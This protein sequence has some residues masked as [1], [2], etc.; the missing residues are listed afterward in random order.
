MYRY[1]M[2]MDFEEIS[3]IRE[4]HMNKKIDV[5]NYINK[6]SGFDSLLTMLNCK[7]E[8]KNVNPECRDINSRE[9]QSVANYELSGFIKQMFEFVEPDIY[10]YINYTCDYLLNYLYPFYKENGTNEEKYK[11]VDALEHWRKY[12]DEIKN[13]TDQKILTSFL[14]NRKNF[15]F[16]FPQ[17]IIGDDKKPLKVLKLCPNLGL[18]VYKNFKDMYWYGKNNIESHTR[19]LLSRLMKVEECHFSDTDYYIFEKLTNVNTAIEIAQKLSEVI[20]TK[21]AESLHEEKN[22]EKYKTIINKL[23]RSIAISPLMY[24]K[25]IGLISHA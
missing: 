18:Y 9:L 4:S 22:T 19:F 8:D 23:I 3:V 14:R 17:I 24:S 21:Q 1:S 25:S 2:F 7:I 6:P 15:K 20:D 16:P 10:Y 12:D 5:K 11:Y 13:D